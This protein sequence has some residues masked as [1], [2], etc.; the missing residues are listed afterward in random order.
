M[1]CRHRFSHFTG[2]WQVR[3]AVLWI[4]FAILRLL[5]STC[6]AIQSCIDAGDSESKRLKKALSVMPKLPPKSWGR[7]GW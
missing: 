2:M 7:N 4:Q 5:L 1:P 3:I 6:Q